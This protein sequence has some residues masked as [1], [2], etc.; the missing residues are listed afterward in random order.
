MNGVK[1]LACGVVLSTA[2][3]LAPGFATATSYPLEG[4]TRTFVGKNIVNT[5]TNSSSLVVRNQTT[6]RALFVAGG[7]GGGSGCGGGGGGGGV[8]EIE[9]L[10]LAPGTYTVTVGSGGTG[11]ARASSAGITR[12]NNGGN[13]SLTLSGV[14]VSNLLPALGGG[15]GGCWSDKNGRNGGCGGGT[16]GGGTKGTGTSGQG[17]DGGTSGSRSTSGG[18]GAGGAGGNGD[19][20]DARITKLASAVGG[21][22]HTSDISGIA[23]AYGGGG[24]GGGG[25]SGYCPPSSGTDGGGS[26]SAFGSNGSANGGDGENGRGGGGGGSGWAGT[27]VHGKGGGYKLTRQPEQYTV[28]EVLRLTEGDLAP[29]ACLSP[30]AEPCTKAAECRTIKM[31]K[32]FYDMTNKYF[33]G[34]TIADLAHTESADNYVI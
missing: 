19:T 8:V 18:G 23:V 12:G 27:G 15:G 32:G 7:G 28:G 24:G 34:I 5:F 21:I 30:D 3:A 31:W 9:D 33:D 17:Y 1:K 11:G 2:A 22:G 25:D 29:V 4:G 10:V 26:G 20:A 6:V 16:V 13:S 14:A